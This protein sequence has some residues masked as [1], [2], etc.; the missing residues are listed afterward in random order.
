MATLDEH[1]AQAAVILLHMELEGA[2]PN[3]SQLR[4]L[5]RGQGQGYKLPTLSK[6][7]HA[8]GVLVG[9][10][11]ERLPSDARKALKAARHRYLTQGSITWEKQSE[12]LAEYGHLVGVKPAVWGWYWIDA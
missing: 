10:R 2:G 3:K 7:P 4:A 11:Y 5:T 8:F 12:H 9:D 1:A 6:L